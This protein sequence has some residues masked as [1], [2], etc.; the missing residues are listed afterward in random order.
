MGSEVVRRQC[1]DPEPTGNSMDVNGREGLVACRAGN[2]A[3][4]RNTNAARVVNSADL[5]GR[6]YF[7]VSA[8]TEGGRALQ[9]PIVAIAMVGEVMR[10]AGGEKGTAQIADS[11]KRKEELARKPR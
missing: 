2:D 4:K 8:A 5:F 11:R 6:S 9:R 10:D 7:R 1:G 3:R